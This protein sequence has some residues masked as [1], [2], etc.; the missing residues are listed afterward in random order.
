MCSLSCLIFL[1]LLCHLLGHAAIKANATST[2]LMPPCFLPMTRCLTH[3]IAGADVADILIWRRDRCVISLNPEILVTFQFLSIILYPTKA[4]AVV[5]IQ[6][7]KKRRCEW[8]DA[9]WCRKPLREHSVEV[10]TIPECQVLL[11][12]KKH[13]A[14]TA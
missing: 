13:F 2:I 3:Q 7:E 6:R 8:T 1:R 12:I 14:S 10:L 9:T 4:G 11:V 5:K